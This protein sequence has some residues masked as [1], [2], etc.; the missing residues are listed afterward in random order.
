MMLTELQMKVLKCLDINPKQS[1][2]DIAENI[3]MTIKQRT[4]VHYVLVSLEKK[5]L[6]KKTPFVPKSIR[7]TK[8]GRE[9][10]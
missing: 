4:N 1:L 8:A 2:A 5:K 6:I 3:G 9:A 10:I 7:L